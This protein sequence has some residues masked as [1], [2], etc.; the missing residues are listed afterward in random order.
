MI[1]ALL[2]LLS[3]ALTWLFFAGL[4]GACIV[5]V[6]FLTDLFRTISKDEPT[7][8]DNQPISG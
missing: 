5:I 4:L 1:T 7:P 2:S 6:L 8:S 3:T